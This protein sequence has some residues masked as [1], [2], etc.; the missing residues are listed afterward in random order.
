MMSDIKYFNPV[1]WR[2]MWYQV[3]LCSIEITEGKS[4]L[5]Y[6]AQNA[7]YK[8]LS[9]AQ[10]IFAVWDS[11]RDKCC[12]C[13]DIKATVTTL[14]VNIWIALVGYNCVLSL[15]LLKWRSK[16][17]LTVDVEFRWKIK[18]QSLSLNFPYSIYIS[19][20]DIRFFWSN[21]CLKNDKV[22]G[23]IKAISLTLFVYLILYS[24]QY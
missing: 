8:S 16:Y 1:K 23:L 3:F 10:P 4:Q 17:T 19:K 18:Y 2:G 20:Y 22:W 11:R 15:T 24:A 9:F 7:N 6:W 12:P 13:F 5:C 14:K 21:I